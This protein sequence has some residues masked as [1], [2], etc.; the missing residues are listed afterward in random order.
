MFMMVLMYSTTTR[1]SQFCT[2][3][4]GFTHQASWNN[5][6]GCLTI[7]FISDAAIEG[8]GWL[9]NVQCGNQFQPFDPHRSL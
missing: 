9:G 6:S 3:P 2:D 4:T 5:P 8:T 7:V 1:S